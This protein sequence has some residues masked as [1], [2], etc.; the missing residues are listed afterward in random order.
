MLNQQPD[1]AFN[2][3]ATLLDSF[4][5]YLDSD[6]I[7]NRYW[8]NS[9]NPPHYPEEFRQIQ[10]Q[11]LIDKINRVPFDSEAA[12]KGTAFNEIVDCLIEHRS[13]TIMMIEP[14]YEVIVQGQV[15]NCEPDERWAEVTE[16]NKVISYKAIYKNREFVFD[17]EL[18][19]EFADYYKGA[20][21]QQF[22]SGILDTA[23]G[24][25]KLYGYIDELMPASV[26]DIKSTGSYTFGKFK[27]HWQHRVYP[28]CLMQNG[29]DV[30]DFEYNIVQL[31]KYGKWE[32][33]TECYTFKPERDIPI[34]RA[35]CEDLIRFLLENRHLITDEKIFNYRKVVA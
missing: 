22:T 31:P 33:F 5:D 7:W 15:D 24:K 32:T 1:I 34:L 18:C 14:V 8:G 3:Y 30:R 25:V 13:S 2:F 23:F 16:T 28:F 12:D 4:T 21:T 26:H 10:F 35:H 6:D 29:N 27:N 19:H 20:L 9:E 11:S 17:K